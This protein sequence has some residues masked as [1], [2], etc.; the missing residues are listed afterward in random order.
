MTLLVCV[1][2]V[3]SGVLYYGLRLLQFRSQS[4]AIATWTTTSAA[5]D[6]RRLGV[7]DGAAIGVDFSGTTGE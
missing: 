3:G 2:K 1:I 6:E 7:L 4:A 5:V